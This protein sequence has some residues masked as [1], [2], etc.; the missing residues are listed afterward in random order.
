MLHFLNA[1]TQPNN[2][3][4][5][6][7]F[8]QNSGASLSDIKLDN[9]G[10]F[11]VVGTFGGIQ[12]FD[13][14]NPGV[15]GVSSFTSIGNNDIVICKYDINLNLIWARQIGGTSKDVAN[16]VCFDTLGNIIVSG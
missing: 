8:P 16:T 5:A 14:L 15:S 1:Q 12:N 10:Y 7:A 2:L 11:C 3:G 4:Y 13:F 9:K 6:W